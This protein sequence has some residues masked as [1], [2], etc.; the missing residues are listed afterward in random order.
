MRIIFDME[1][2]NKLINILLYIQVIYEKCVYSL[3]LFF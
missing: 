2:I 1:H 3:F